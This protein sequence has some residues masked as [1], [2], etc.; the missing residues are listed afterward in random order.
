MENSMEILQKT[1][2]KI[3]IWFSNPTTGHISQGNHNWKKNT[4]TPVF[5]TALFAIGRIWKQSRCLSTDERTKN[6]GYIYTME[7][8]PTIRGW[9]W[10]TYQGSNGDA[11]MEKTYGLS[12]E[13]R[14][15]GWTE[16]YMLWGE[17]KHICYHV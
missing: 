8:Y 4:C 9:Y 12:W 17:L 10:C 14:R 6:Q 15:V 7:Y 5:I 2:N 1:R 3:T 11:D 16:R 13:T